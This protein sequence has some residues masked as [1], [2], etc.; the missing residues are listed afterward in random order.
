MGY[1]V[2]IDI[3]KSYFQFEAADDE[4]AMA[5]KITAAVK[6]LLPQQADKVLPLFGNLLSVKFGNEWDERLK[7][8]E[9]EQIQ[10]QTF[11]ALRDFFFALATPSNSPPPTVP[12]RK[13]DRGE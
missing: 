1:G 4:R 8:V 13:G 5:E 12:L 2:F 10:R 6:E 11:T 9:P 7:F 3:L